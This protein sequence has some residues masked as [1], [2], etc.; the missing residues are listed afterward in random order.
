MASEAVP[1]DLLTHV[2]SYLVEN[3]LPK[4]ANS[5]KRECRI[6]SLSRPC[7][8]SYTPELCECIASSRNQVTLCFL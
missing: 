8:Y 3:K 7:S 5:L 4:A 1:S 2:Y 6:V